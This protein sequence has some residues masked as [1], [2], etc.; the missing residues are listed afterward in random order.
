MVTKV[1]IRLEAREALTFIGTTEKFWEGAGKEW[2]EFGRRRGLE[3]LQ[4]EVP[5]GKTGKLHDSCWSE[6]QGKTVRIGT[7]VPYDEFVDGEGKTD[8]S[9]GRFV[10]AI[11]K[12]LV[13]RK[14]TPKQAIMKRAARRGIPGKLPKGTKIKFHDA[15]IIP[16]PKEKGYVTLAYGYFDGKK[17]EIHIAA[18][19][20]RRVVERTLTHEL[21][22]AVQYA[23]R[24]HMSE[25][26]ADSVAASLEP[27]I[28]EHPGS[29]KTPYSKRT[30][31]R[32]REEMEGKMFDIMRGAPS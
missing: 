3:I 23:S 24:L 26:E 13:T 16:Y 28:G 32:L 12:R 2:L 5:K 4:E 29:K 18:K 10:P 27:K 14:L 17:R 7:A 25:R 19:Q 15:G 1:R 30:H 20:P 8:A 21:W 31:E 9:P 22:H 6:I 11:E